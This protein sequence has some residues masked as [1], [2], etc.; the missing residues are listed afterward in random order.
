M[1]KKA[2][3]HLGF[4][5]VFFSIWFLGKII[6][7]MWSTRVPPGFGKSCPINPIVG[8]G[9]KRGG[10][11]EKGLRKE[12]EKIQKSLHE[13]SKTGK[14]IKER[15]CSKTWLCGNFFSVYPTESS[16]LSLTINTCIL[17]NFFNTNLYLILSSHTYETLSE[18]KEPLEQPR[19]TQTS[20]PHH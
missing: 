13:D 3:K 18:K 16:Y 4:L 12:R 8:G 14:N 7:T 17:N 11:G 19:A 1:I 6:S 10:K 9:R 20:I 15:R 5:P 2:R